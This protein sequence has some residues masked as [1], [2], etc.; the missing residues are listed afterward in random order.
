MHKSYSASHYPPLRVRVAAW[1]FRS[2]RAD[3][4]EF[5]AQM[6]SHEFSEQTLLT[7]FEQ[8]ARRHDRWS[9]R[10]RL[11][12]YWAQRYATSGANLI[13]TWRCTVPESDLQSLVVAQQAGQQALMQTLS[14]LAVQI[15]L[16]RS[17]SEHF[18]QTIAVGII[19]ATVALSCLLAL[20]LWTVPK[21]LAAFSGVPSH[22][23]GQALASL[24]QWV[25]IVKEH[26][27]IGTLLGTGIIAL[28]VWSVLGLTGAIRDRLDGFGIWRI[29]RD[30]QA[31]RFLTGTA[32]MLNALSNTGVSLRTVLINQR[33]YAN[34]WLDDHLQRMIEQL[35]AGIDPL[36]S[37][38]TGLLS[39]DVWWRFVDIARVR[40]LSC[41]LGQT[42]AEIG[43][44][45]KARLRRRA[46]VLR[47]LLLG[48]ALGCVL[49]VGWWHL[50]AIEE[51]RQ[52][53]TLFH[54][55]M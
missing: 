32:T 48:L 50:R 14:C 51:L 46:I 26:W 20:P 37:L 12:A 44:L 27:L 17:C 24:I 39:G 7:I 54:G 19:A 13:D 43:E 10:G 9:V 55:L 2:S 30:V 5:L 38:N 28:L 40:G 11:A 42:S 21:L 31:M 6:L 49:I 34:A 33:Q 1:C 8:D 25:S 3:Y 47:W 23:Y 45:L 35:D 22:H 15:R 52:G 41:G 36:T 29:Y 18:W 53:L 4:Y 16:S